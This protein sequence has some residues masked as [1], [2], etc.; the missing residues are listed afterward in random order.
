MTASEPTPDA[1]DD[2]D[3]GRIDDV[4]KS[5]GYRIGPFEVENAL[6]SHEAVLEAAVTSA[7]NHFQMRR[8]REDSGLGSTEATTAFRSLPPTRVKTGYPRF[9]SSQI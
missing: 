1:A 3:I 4:I 8:K 9:R 2:F 6:V 7:P 5:A